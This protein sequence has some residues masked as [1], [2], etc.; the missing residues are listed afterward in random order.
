LGYLTSKDVPKYIHT[1]LPT[2]NLSHMAPSLGLVTFGIA[3]V[4]I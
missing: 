2:Y 4:Y 1:Y 3:Y